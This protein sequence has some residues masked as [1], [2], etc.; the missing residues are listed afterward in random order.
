MG[1]TRKHLSKDGLLNVVR[2]SVR[3]EKLKELIPI[4]IQPVLIIQSHDAMD[5][6]HSLFAS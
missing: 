6:T 4:S 3:R 2:Q 1:L 5:L